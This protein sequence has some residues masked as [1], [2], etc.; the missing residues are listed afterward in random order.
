MVDAARERLGERLEDWVID[1]LPVRTRAEAEGERA[2]LLAASR[3]EDVV[4]YL[5][6]LRAAGLEVA[7]LDIGPASVARV[8]TATRDGSVDDNV[9]TVNFGE[10]GSFLT[11]FS[12]RRL[13][14]DREVSLGQRALLETV[15]RGLD[16]SASE[17]D[18][19]LQR[20]G[21][22]PQLSAPP[23][24]EPAEVSATVTEILRPRLLELRDEIAKAALYA[25]SQTRGGS[26][27]QVLLLG[28]AARWP[29]LDALLGSV[30]KLPEG[31]LTAAAM[32]CVVAGAVVLAGALAA[33]QRPTDPGL[34]SGLTNASGCALRGFTAR[35]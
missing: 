1:F 12:G 28:A 13:I 15:A 33:G 17:A 25:A 19:L 20:Y 5:E 26:I 6:L 16:V 34:L 3:R 32:A 23:G 35:D 27:A 14:L 24:G 9:L 8:V 7:A 29:R 31:A 10:D 30:L 22:L 21:L 4:A 11:V 18:E 2:A